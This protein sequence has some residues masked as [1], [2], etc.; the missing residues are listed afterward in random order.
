MKLLSQKQIETLAKFECKDLF[1]TSFFLDTS[2]NRLTKKEIQLSLKNLLV[3]SRKKLKVMSLSKAKKESLEQDLE[4]IE[5]YC[6]QNL[7][8]AKFVGLA[9]FSGSKCDLWKVFNL[10]KSPRN[11]IIFDH[12][13]YIRPLSA[14]LTEYH[15]TCVLTFDRKEAKWYD[16]FMG[17]IS[18]LES[19]QS[20]VPSRI[21][22]GGWEGYKSK[23]IERHMTSRLHKFFKKTAQETFTLMKKY[24]FEWLLLGCKDE[25]Y[26]ELEPLLHTYL[27][28]KIKARFKANPGDSANKI[29]QETLKIKDKLKKQEKELIV[30]K[31]ISE[32]E[33][34]GLAVSGLEN[35]LHKLNR[36]EVHTLLVTR[37]FSQPGKVC[38]KCLFLYV[39][40]SECP[41]CRV[42]TKSLI[43]VIDEAVEAAL[44]SRSEVKHIN[45]PSSLDKYGGI[46]AFLRYKI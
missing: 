10:V 28:E 15:R 40:E 1:T 14:I 37:H 23:R 5:N 13:P 27:K 29:L 12:N 46:G 38:P 31:F 21:K 35:T 36:G 16:I 18:E 33:K 25:Y 24:N 26:T 42:K 30:Q 19:L 41:S 20:D 34:D 43:D 22:E 4:K 17:E 6:K 3:N 44:N 32:H 8:G 11:M 45:P 2:K 9:I 7:S 39:D